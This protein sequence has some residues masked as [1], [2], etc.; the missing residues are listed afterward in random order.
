MKLM[1]LK[2]K[3]AEPYCYSIA[4]NTK[5]EHLHYICVRLLEPAELTWKWL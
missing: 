5:S 1:T 3:A 2:L 4:R